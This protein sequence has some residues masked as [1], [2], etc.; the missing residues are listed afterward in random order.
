[1]VA[2]RFLVP[3]VGVRIPARLPFDTL[4]RVAPSRARH[5]PLS[6]AMNDDRL[7]PQ[8]FRFCPKCGAEPLRPLPS[9]EHSIECPDCRFTLYF[10]PSC[11]A[12]AL[13]EDRKGNLLVIERARSPAKGKYGVPGGFCDYGERLEEAI[14][15][16]VKEEVNLDLSSFSFLASFPNEY[17][18]RSVIYPVTDAYF[19]A[20]VE[21]FEQLKAE[22]SEVAGIHFVNP[23]E[24]PPDKWAFPSHRSAIEHLLEPHPNGRSTQTNR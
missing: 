18:Y 7:L 11:A 1:M 20:T 2:L 3:L 19:T 4:F 17:L 10:N 13:I 9:S 12:A 23:A 21:S 5:R 6:P 24:V 14:A 16:E 22:T 8:H 15:R